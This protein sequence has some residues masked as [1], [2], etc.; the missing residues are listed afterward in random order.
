MPGACALAGGAGGLTG[1][2]YTGR[3]PVCGTISRRIGCPGIGR[4]GCP[5]P[6]CIGGR[7]TGAVGGVGVIGV[8]DGVLAAG[9]LGSAGFA[10]STGA[11]EVLRSSPLAA[12][13]HHNAR[14]LA[15]LR[16]NETRSRRRLLCGNCFCRL[17]RR[18]GG[19]RLLDRL[20]CRGSS[21]SCFYHWLRRRGRRCHRLLHRRS[22]RRVCHRWLHRFSRLCR[23]T[24]GRHGCI[25]L[26]MNCF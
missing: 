6:P 19:L 10:C 16:R 17:D 13:R 11:A 8:A 12:G 15:R 1:A 24:R 18:R 4:P 2:E 7:C 25:G 5:V 22:W 3:G 26:L 23:G 9:A 21:R 14:R 20:L